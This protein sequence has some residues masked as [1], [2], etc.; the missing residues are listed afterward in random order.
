M[1]GR[2]PLLFLVN[3]F[4]P[5]YSQSP[6]SLIKTLEKRLCDKEGR[7][8]PFYSQGPCLNPF[9][10]AAFV[11]Y[12]GTNSKKAVFTTEFLSIGHFLTW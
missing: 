3:G 8:Y 6:P 4:L 11:S 7:S 2:I 9:F 10:K 5:S 12:S 1:E